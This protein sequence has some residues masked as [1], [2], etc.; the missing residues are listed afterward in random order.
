MRKQ[1]R[2]TEP[3]GLHVLDETQ[4]VPDID[5][6]AVGKAHGSRQ[7]LLVVTGRHPFGP[8]NGLVAGQNHHEVSRGRAVAAYVAERFI[9]G[10]AAR[11]ERV[12]A[13]G[14]VRI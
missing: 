2:Q 5:S 11:G 13:E 9:L 4:A 1:V 3:G 10:Q 8:R 7:G 6:T 14:G 12:A